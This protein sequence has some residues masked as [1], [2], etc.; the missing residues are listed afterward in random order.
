[1]DEEIVKGIKAMTRGMEAIAFVAS[2][3]YHARIVKFTTVINNNTKREKDVN[4][5]DQALNMY[6]LFQGAQPFLSR[7]GALPRDFLEENTNFQTN[8]S[9]LKY[10]KHPCPRIVLSSIHK[11]NRLIA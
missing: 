6:T 8:V 1:M 7:E 9:P 11:L 10:F 2:V 3:K 5:F 4:I